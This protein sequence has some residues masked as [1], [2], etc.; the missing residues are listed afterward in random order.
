MRKAVYAAALGI[1]LATLLLSTRGALATSPAQGGGLLRGY[2]Y[3][4]DMYDELIPLVWVN[5][6]AT[7][8]NYKIGT[9]TGGGGEYEM[10]VPLGAY[11]LSVNAPGYKPYSQS[12]FVG[13]GSAS[14][15]NMYLYQ[16]GV[17]VPEFPMQTF[18]LAISFVVAVSLLT[19]VKRRKR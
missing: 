3:G 5:V 8:A 15:I 11:N 4:F 10:Y 1:I 9:S 17:P 18:A 7:N 6:T 14:T 19:K 16:S 12:V 2:V 13:E